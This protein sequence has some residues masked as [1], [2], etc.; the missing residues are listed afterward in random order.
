MHFSICICAYISNF[1]N[2][3]QSIHAYCKI[4]IK[5][6]IA[7]MKTLQFYLQEEVNFLYKIQ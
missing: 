7:T 5:Y 4:Q 3:K 2:S 6:A 1:F